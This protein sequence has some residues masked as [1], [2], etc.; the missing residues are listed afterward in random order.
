MAKVIKQVFKAGLG[1]IRVIRLRYGDQLW[2][3]MRTTSFRSEYNNY[4]VG[5]NCSVL[6]NEVYLL[7]DS[8][9]LLL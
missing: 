1:T 8:K 9:K 4:V 3:P 7:N 6:G 5:V 2:F